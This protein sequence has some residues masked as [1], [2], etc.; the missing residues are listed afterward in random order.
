ME[1][2]DEMLIAA[3]KSLVKDKVLPTHAT[4]DTY[5]H[6]YESVRRAIESALSKQ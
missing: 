2:T 3:I 6:H 4:M 5:T 1:V